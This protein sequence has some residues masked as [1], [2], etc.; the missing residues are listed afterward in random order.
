M[1]RALQQRR[2]AIVAPRP[3][4]PRDKLSRKPLRGEAPEWPPLRPSSE[5]KPYQ[6]PHAADGVLLL[7]RVSS[8]NYLEALD[9]LHKH[10]RPSSYVEI[11][12]RQG[13]SLTRARCPAVAID[14]KPEICYPLGSQTQIFEETSDSF[15]ANR[16]LTALIGGPFDL[17]FVDGMHKAEYVLRDFFNLERHAGRN[18]IIVLDDVLPEDIRWTTRHRETK[19]W[20]GDVYKVIP[21]LCNSRPD[22][23]IDTFD[24][25]MKGMA[26]VSNLTPQNISLRENYQAHEAFLK[27]DASALRSV[28]EIRAALEPRPVRE[29]EGYVIELAEQGSYD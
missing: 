12:C 2:L 26:I 16:D 20:V 4:N 11:G 1:I 7:L 24:I 22:L 28:G 15:F 5:L 25:E 21:L 29:F 10:L 3:G 18:S 19:A 27:S 9:L 14:P 23:K 17:A 6:L 8:M 13:C